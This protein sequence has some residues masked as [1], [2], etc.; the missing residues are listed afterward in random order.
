M[1]MMTKMVMLLVL[2]GLCV[3]S[4]GDILVYKLSAKCTFFVF[5]DGEWQVTSP[6]LKGYHVIDLNYDTHTIDQSHEFIYWKDA[7]G[8]KFTSNI[9]NL[10]LIPVE[11]GTKTQWAIMETDRDV[12]GEEVIGG[13]ILVLTGSVRERNIGTGVNRKVA[14]TVSGYDVGGTQGEDIEKGAVSLTFYPAWT[15]WANGDD[16]DEG[17]QDFDATVQM[18][19]DYFIDRGY[20]EA[21][22]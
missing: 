13:H 7:E 17:N 10:R 8:K 12:V 16:D 5:E 6:T 15:Y 14:A 18:I 9:L 20:E 2:L 1:K 11:Y 21:E 19:T 22:L 4:Y 3:P